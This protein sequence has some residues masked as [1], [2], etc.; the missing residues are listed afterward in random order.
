LCRVLGVYPVPVRSAGILIVAAALLAGCGGGGSGVSPAAARQCLT[1]AKLRVVGGPAS[2][3]DTNAPNT[4]L[5]VSAPGAGAFLAYYDDIGRADKLAVMIRR[6][7]RAFHGSLE[8]HGHLT[9]L[10]VRGANTP[11]AERIKACIL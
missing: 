7:A 1:K 6:R 5:I 4:E 2:K 10:W 9:I 11:D 8:R 3:G